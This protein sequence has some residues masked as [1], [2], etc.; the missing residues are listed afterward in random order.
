MIPEKQKEITFLKP[1]KDKIKIK[2]TK[3]HDFRY[4]NTT[5]GCLSQFSSLKLV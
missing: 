2:V 1:L 5:D 4:L 3:E